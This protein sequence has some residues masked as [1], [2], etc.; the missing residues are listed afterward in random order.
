MD[1]SVPNFHVSEFVFNNSLLRILF[2]Q[3]NFFILIFVVRQ[4]K[5]SSL[6]DF[7][8]ILLHVLLPQ[9]YFLLL[10][11]SLLLL[12]LFIF[13]SLVSSLLIGTISCEV[14]LLAAVVA[15]SSRAAPLALL[16]RTVS[17]QVSWFIAVV[18]VLQWSFNLFFFWAVSC[19]MALFSTLKTATVLNSSPTSSSASPLSFA[20]F[21]LSPFFLSLDAS[22]YFFSSSSS[23]RAARLRLQ[24][25]RELCISPSSLVLRN[26]LLRYSIFSRGSSVC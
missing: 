21:S 16:L 18:A 5:F 14:T 7:I 22:R 25:F 24:L 1:L 23:K 9:L 10:L 15:S 17:C 20:L 8:E 2:D 11:F 3:F 12:S 19:E 4:C 13:F 26:T 6:S